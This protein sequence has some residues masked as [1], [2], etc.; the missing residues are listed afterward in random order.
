[1]LVACVGKILVAAHIDREDVSDCFVPAAAI[2]DVAADLTS[3]YRPCR[4]SS[5][6]K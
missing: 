5:W 2:H 1:M 6:E 3:G 4:L